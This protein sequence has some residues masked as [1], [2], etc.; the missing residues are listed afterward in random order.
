MKNVQ[1]KNYYS[2]E[3]LEEFKQIILDKLSKAKKEIESI[4]RA[5][6]KNYT[7]DTNFN[8][9]L[10]ED[11]AELAEEDNLCRLATRQHK[12]I[13]HLEAALERIKNGTYGI[14]ASTGTLIDKD[15]LKVVPHTTHSVVAKQQRS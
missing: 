3:E 14:C 9:K 13:T 12:F 7:E 4:K 1:I 10:F 8:L 6:S 15:R 11:G 2:N 5:L